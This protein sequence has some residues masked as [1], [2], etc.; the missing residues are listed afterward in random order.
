MDEALTGVA[1]AVGHAGQGRHLQFPQAL[2]G[3]ADHLAQQVGIGALFQQPKGGPLK[4][5]TRASFMRNQ[6]RL[7]R[8]PEVYAIAEIWQGRR[9]RAIWRVRRAR[10]LI[11]R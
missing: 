7:R 9:W 4:P 2:G 5:S 8:L 10:S 11:Y 3:K 6:V 1:L